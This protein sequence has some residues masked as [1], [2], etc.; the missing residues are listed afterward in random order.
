M[1]NSIESKKLRNYIAQYIRNF[2]NTTNL[3]E[4]GAVN[5]E[6]RIGTL[7]ELARAMARA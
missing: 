1:K 5:M 2:R 6:I 7:R 3:S 4:Q